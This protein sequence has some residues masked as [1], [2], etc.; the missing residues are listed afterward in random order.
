[1]AL[2]QWVCD[3]GVRRHLFSSK[4]LLSCC[5]RRSMQSF[6]SGLFCDILLC[7]WPSPAPGLLHGVQWYSSCLSTHTS[8][9]SVLAKTCFFRTCHSLIQHNLLQKDL[10]WLYSLPARA[11]IQDTQVCCGISLAGDFQEPSEKWKLRMPEVWDPSP[12]QEAGLGHLLGA[13]HLRFCYSMAKERSWGWK[14]TEEIT[15]FWKTRNPSHT[16]FCFIALCL[17]F[18]NIRKRLLNFSEQT[19]A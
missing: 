6:Y 2:L 8:V 10:G 19:Y 12:L 7:L 15:L 16:R 9:V 1:M 14:K 17:D 5:G 4:R 13:C 3:W 18:A 11:V